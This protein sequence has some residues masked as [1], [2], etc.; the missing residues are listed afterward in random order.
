MDWATHQLYE[1]DLGSLYLDF[2]PAHLDDDEEGDL[3][4]GLHALGSKH[5]G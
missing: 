1:R 3:L 5:F 4:A 2:A